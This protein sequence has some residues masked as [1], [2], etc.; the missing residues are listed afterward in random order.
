MDQKASPIRLRPHHILCTRTF[1]GSGYNEA[2]VDNMY[3]VLDRMNE[4]GAVIQLTVG[5]DDICAQ[6]P[7]VVDGVCEFG[8]SV[9][10]KDASILAFL[11]LLAGTSYK[12]S[13]LR[14]L[15]EERL[16]TVDDVGAICGECDWSETCNKILREIKEER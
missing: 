7:H 13:E 12:A 5:C 9:D 14:S 16:E 1:T 11:D 10:N 3:F 6:C 4:R 2:F 8:R 15:L